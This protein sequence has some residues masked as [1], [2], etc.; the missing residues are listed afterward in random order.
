MSE[1]GTH[2]A[3]HGYVNSRQDWEIHEASHSPEKPDATVARGTGRAIWPAE[4]T[5]EIEVAF[6][7]VPD[8]TEIKLPEK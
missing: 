7:H 3:S 1:K 4:A 6:G 2:V 8:E 5:Y